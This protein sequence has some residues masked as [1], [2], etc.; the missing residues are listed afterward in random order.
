LP[1]GVLGAIGNC[2]GF[3]FRKY[4]TS[5][6]TVLVASLRPPWV[7]SLAPHNRLEEL[8][9][10]MMNQAR[11]PSWIEL[12]VK[13]LF[14][15]MFLQDVKTLTARSGNSFRDAELVTFKLLTV[16]PK[17]YGF[18]AILRGK[19]IAAPH[20]H[21]QQLLYACLLCPLR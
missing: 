20:N 2:W 11:R 5:L 3:D 1:S 16:L 8:I 19:Y 18:I 15:R 7:Q 4:R 12:V 10:G 17:D 13:H 9:L 6:S 14:A 21:V